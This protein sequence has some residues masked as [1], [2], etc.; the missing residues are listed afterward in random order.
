MNAV[1][2]FFR[3]PQVVDF[4]ERVTATAFEAG[5]AVYFV[6]VPDD[7][8]LKAA[9]G[10][11]GLAAVKYIYTHVGASQASKINVPA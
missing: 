5:A 6:G 3:R 8:T 1:S 10:A 11:A 2:A 4:I 9:V 7:K